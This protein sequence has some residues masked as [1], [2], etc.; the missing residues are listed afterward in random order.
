MSVWQTK[1]TV[2]DLSEKQAEQQRDH[3][4]ELLHPDIETMNLQTEYPID[5]VLEPLKTH[6]SA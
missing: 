6:I 4:R 3:S 2:R 5:F 1:L